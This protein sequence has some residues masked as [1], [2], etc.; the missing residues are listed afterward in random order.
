MARRRNTPAGTPAD[1]FL[2]LQPC[3]GAIHRLASETEFI[4]NPRCIGTAC[5]LQGSLERLISMTRLSLQ[6][7]AGATPE[8][9]RAARVRRGRDRLRRERADQSFASIFGG[10]D[11]NR[12]LLLV[13]SELRLYPRLVQSERRKAVKT[14]ILA[15]A[16]VLALG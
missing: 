8:T 9:A 16:A 15:A 14:M 2:T 13:T 6:P 7:Y 4:G 12:K 1:L 5:S 3:Q 10:D 11:T